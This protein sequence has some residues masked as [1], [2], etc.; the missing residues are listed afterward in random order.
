MVCSIAFLIAGCDKGQKESDDYIILWD[1]LSGPTRGGVEE[2]AE[3]LEGCGLF[4]EHP[5][6]R[7]VAADSLGGSAHGTFFFASGSINAEIKSFQSLSF[8]WQPGDDRIIISSLPMEKIV[9]VIDESKACPTIRFKFLIDSY[10]DETD[11]MIIRV[12]PNIVITPEF[13]AHATIR[14]NSSDLE[15]EIYLPFQGKN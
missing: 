5:L 4:G 3:F 1:N 15:K 9:V 2:T 13:I 14:I 7:F 11:C 8:A 12:N 6:E 10:L